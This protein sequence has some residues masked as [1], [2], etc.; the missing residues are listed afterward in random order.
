[1]IEAKEVSKRFPRW[2]F[3]TFFFEFL[4]G[5]MMEVDY[6]FSNGLKSPPSFL[7]AIISKETPEW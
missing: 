3:L 2:W 7:Q 5:E 6:L 1:M 4:P